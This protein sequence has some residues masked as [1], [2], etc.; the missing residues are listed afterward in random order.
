MGQPQGAERLGDE[1]QKDDAGKVFDI[2]PGIDDAHGQTVGKNRKGEP[3]DDPQDDELWKEHLSGVVDEHGH[4]SQNAQRAVGLIGAHP[5]GKEQGSKKTLQG[6]KR[7]HSY[8][9]VY[10]R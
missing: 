7:C 1:G 5:L 9:A 2:I 3:P 8:L 10:V 6:W 4:K